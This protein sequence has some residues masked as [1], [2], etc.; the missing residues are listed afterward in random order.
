MILSRSRPSVILP[1]IMFL[2]GCVTVG[3]GFVPNFPGLVGF[4]V[5]VGILE[6]GFAPGVLLLMSSWYKRAEQSK[7]FAIY[8]SAAILS[9]AFGGLIAGAITSGLD[10]AHGI[11]GWRWLFIVEGAATAGWSLIAHFILPDFPANTKWLNERER[12]LAIQRL[13]ADHAQAATEDTPQLRHFEAL[14]ACLKTWNVWLFV[15]GYMVSEPSS[16]AIGSTLGFANPR[17]TVQRRSSAL[18]LS[19]TSTQ[20]WS[21]GLATLPTLRST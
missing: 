20:R 19:R 15:V 17:G 21:M 7:R 5:V 6:A 14:K 8:I 9:G 11:A 1:G 16:K 18:P 2:W 3:M 10:G 12:E 4:R 13:E